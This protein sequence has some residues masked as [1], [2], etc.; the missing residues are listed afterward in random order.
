MYKLTQKQCERYM[1]SEYVNEVFDIII[2]CADVFSKCLEWEFYVCR[3]GR[4]QVSCEYKN[5]PFA[6]EAK[7]H[8]M[9]KFDMMRGLDMALIRIRKQLVEYMK[10]DAEKKKAAWKPTA[11]TIYYSVAY[12]SKTTVRRLFVDEHSFPNELDLLIGNYFKT[13]EEAYAHIEEIHSKLDKI[14]TYAKELNN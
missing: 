8:P 13:F 5:S 6:A 4:V 9:D 3:S 10:K 11:G 14:K 1:T 12:D 7:C 2:R